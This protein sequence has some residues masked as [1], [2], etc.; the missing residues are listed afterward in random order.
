MR[1]RWLVVL[2]LWTS[3][4]LARQLNAASAITGGVHLSEDHRKLTLVNLDPPLG[5]L[6]NVDCS[7][8]AC[9][10]LYAFEYQ[11]LDEPPTGLPTVTSAETAPGDFTRV[12]FTLDG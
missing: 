4:G 3:L 5:I 1:Q 2:A 11:G 8:P 12:V 9:A 10:K 6:Q 7:G